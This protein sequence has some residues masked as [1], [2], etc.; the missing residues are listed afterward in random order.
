MSE[1]PAAETNDPSEIDHGELFRKSP[2]HFEPGA[3]RPRDRNVLWTLIVATA[4][5]VAFLALA[6]R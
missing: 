3:M 4:A 2:R 6:S 5:T 1:L